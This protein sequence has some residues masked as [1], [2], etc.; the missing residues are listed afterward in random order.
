MT[1][2]WRER[3][4]IA[5][6]VPPALRTALYAHVY[7][8]ADY[9]TPN[10]WIEVL[11]S[12][13]IATFGLVLNS[14]AVVIGA[15][16]ISPL[17]GPII[18][19][20]LALTTADLYLG[21]RSFF[22]LFFSVAVALGFS[23]LIVWLLPF[24]T[25]TSEI[26]AR[27]QPNLLD[28]AVALASG[29]AGSIQISRSVTSK[30][31]TTLPGVAIA[32]ALMPPLCTVGFGIG[33]GFR[34]DIVGGAFLLFL[35]NLAAIIFAAFLVFMLI[36]MDAHD[37]RDALDET[38]I[39]KASEDRLYRGLQATFLG[40][41]LGDVN[42]PQWR[43][44]MIVVLLLGLYWPLRGSFYQLRDEAVARAAVESAVRR[45][46]Q[47][48]NLVAQSLQVD[49][50]TLHLY[51]LTTQEVSPADIESVKKELNE[52]TH[53]SVDLQVRRVAAEEDITR[54]RR[55]LELATRP[56]ETA[57]PPP[58]ALDDLR[59]QALARVETEIVPIWPAESADRQSIEVVLGYDSLQVRIRYQAKVALPDAVRQTI[60][61]SLRQRLK[62]NSIQ[63]VL[64]RVR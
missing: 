51:V 7:E 35:T 29:I 64:D 9:S 36:R 12:A 27:T 37:V 26:L 14:P 24:H 53:K 6:G 46:V 17:M 2:S 28:L 16:L 49:A 8:L 3:A 62:D 60:E 42:R 10:Y 43:I 4:S 18:S 52:A 63:V 32:V 41:A 57:P 45:L 20:G 15:M 47:R 56:A 39:A 48:S 23:G 55:S 33:S 61:N 5:L 58:L 31:G 40:R 54:L 50:D 25:P 21:L 59:K 30:P 13:A 44:A 22:G 1:L 34:W 19:A 38:V 11:I